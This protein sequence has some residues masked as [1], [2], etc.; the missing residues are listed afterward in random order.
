MSFKVKFSDK[1]DPRNVLSYVNSNKKICNQFQNIL[2][3]H[4]VGSHFMPKP[5]HNS[6]KIGTFKSNLEVNGYL[7]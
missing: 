1:Y 6:Q 5:T 2:D 4:Y 3:T 7:F